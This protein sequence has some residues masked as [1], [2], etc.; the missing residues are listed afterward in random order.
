[1]FLKKFWV[2]RSPGGKKKGRGGQP[3]ERSWGACS[4]RSVNFTDSYANGI[5]ELIIHAA[6]SCSSL[7]KNES[8][9][10]LHSC[11]DVD[12]SRAKDC[13]VLINIEFPARVNEY[14]RDSDTISAGAIQK[15]PCRNCFAFEVSNLLRRETCCVRKPVMALQSPNICLLKQVFGKVGCRFAY[16]VHGRDSLHGRAAVERLRE[17]VDDVLAPD[18]VK[19]LHVCIQFRTCTRFAAARTT[20]RQ[21]IKEEHLLGS[22]KRQNRD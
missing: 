15:L 5:L 17:I 1:M 14:L 16:S 10:L 9:W 8:V 22:F 11:R 4:Y 19:Q 13:I 21:K 2:I 3:D 7:L 6:T 12:S 20:N 18:V